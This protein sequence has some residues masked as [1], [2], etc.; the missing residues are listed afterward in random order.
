MYYETHYTSEIAYRQIVEGLRKV[1]EMHEWICE[2]KNNSFNY[3]KEN[4]DIKY[5]YKKINEFIN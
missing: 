5:A 1:S 3:L 4:F 2:Y